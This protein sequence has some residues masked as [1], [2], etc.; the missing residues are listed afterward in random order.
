MK[1]KKPISNKAKDPKKVAA[2]KARAAKAVRINGQFVTNFFKEELV[3]DAAAVGYTGKLQ[4]F[5]DQ[6][7]IVYSNLYDTGE[8]RAVSPKA[9]S[10]L[11]KEAAMYQGKLIL[12]INGIDREVSLDELKYEVLRIE[13]ALMSNES[14]AGMAFKPILT[15]SGKMIV[16]LPDVSEIDDM[17]GEGTGEDLSELMERGE[18]IVI[19]ISS[20]K[21]DTV[22]V[23][24]KERK[25]K[26]V[27]KA[28]KDAKTK[29]RAKRRRR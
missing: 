20:K 25:M 22:R 26:A 4:T 9:D 17:E 3:K 27:K 2:G 13:Q 7:E 28:L 23:E 6:H 12:R 5:L 21:R 18:G 14:C 8:L 24:K 19:Y 29:S 16:E 1:N 10:T 15:F 11:F